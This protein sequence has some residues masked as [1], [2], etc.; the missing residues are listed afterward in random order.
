MAL[1]IP[2]SRDCTLLISPIALSRMRSTF[3][4]SKRSKE[5]TGNP[6]LYIDVKV[7]KPE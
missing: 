5:R 3:A 7:K 6:D 1:S 2:A 4:W